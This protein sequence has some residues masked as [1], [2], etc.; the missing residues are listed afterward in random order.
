M[1]KVTG[2]WVV[3]ILVLAGAAVALCM[4]VFADGGNQGKCEKI[5]SAPAKDSESLVS[6]G[7][8]KSKRK[9]RKGAYADFTEAIRLDPQNKE[10]YYERAFT[11]SWDERE[12]GLA[13]LRKAIKIDPDYKEAL[14]TLGRWQSGYSSLSQGYKKQAAAT[15]GINA[16]TK[17]IEIYPDCNM[18]VFRLRADMYL[19]LDPPNCKAAITDRK[20]AVELNKG[21]DQDYE[22]L[23]ETK[24]QCG[25]YLG[26]IEVFND[27][28]SKKEKFFH[29]D[30]KATYD[31]L[32]GIAWLHWAGID[33]KDFSDYNIAITDKRMVSKGIEFLN[34]AIKSDSSE[35]TSANHSWNAKSN[36]AWKANPFKC[37]HLQI[38][39]GYRGM[40]F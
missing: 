10:T 34:K 23:A 7:L 25:D 22:Y 26:A 2:I 16:L 28:L 33:V 9:D 35:C 1:K 30:D 38:S 27:I 14:W 29:F 15:E 21:T 19:S 8:C 20:K 39:L 12:K 32:T 13:D 36:K 31:E 40:A 5:L 17:L 24:E 3:V 37:S 11:Y 18:V 4:P 6:R